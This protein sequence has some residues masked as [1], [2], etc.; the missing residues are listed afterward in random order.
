MPMVDSS[1][2]TQD[3]AAGA[4]AT[5]QLASLDGAIAALEET[6]IPVADEGF[7]RGD[8]VFEVV[9]VYD[10]RPFALGD[11]LDRLER[12][13]ANLRLDGDV[14]RAQLEREIP[15]LLYARGGAEFDGCLRIVL[16]RGGRRLLVTEPLPPM[17]ERVRVAF[18]TCAPTRVLDAIK[19]LSYAANVLCTRIARERGFDEALMVTPHGRVLEA[20]TSSFFW[21]TPEGELCTPPLDD[22]IL[23]SI[24]RERVMRLVDVRERPAPIDDV[25]EAREAFLCSTTREVHPV[26]AIEGHELPTEPPIT[27]AAAALLRAHIE[28]ELH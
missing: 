20:P 27:G 13:A 1:K 5:R 11:H 2:A 24:T 21:V 22:H 9:R 15:E 14:P 18:V 3:P 25:L 26:A 12:S 4:V 16:T 6:F 8:G 17:P 10:G 19:S 28:A 7:I 23:A